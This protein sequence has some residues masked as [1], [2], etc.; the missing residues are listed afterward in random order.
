MEL[1]KKINLR[2]TFIKNIDVPFNIQMLN[3]Q[4][5]RSL[6]V[7][8]VSSIKKRKHTKRLMLNMFW[9]QFCLI[10]Y[11]SVSIF[12]RI[13]SFIYFFSENNC[14]LGLFLLI[15]FLKHI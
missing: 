8:L 12:F 2:I 4:N 5:Y 1:G 11:N 13:L 7:N 9:K 3:K 14:Q 6:P 10:L 15:I